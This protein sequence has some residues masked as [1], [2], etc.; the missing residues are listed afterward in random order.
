MSPNLAVLLAACLTD[1]Y[2]YY[3]TPRGVFTGFKYKHA[4]ILLDKT[5]LGVLLTQYIYST[6]T[7][8]GKKPPSH[9]FPHRFIQF[10]TTPPPIDPYHNALDKY[11]TIHHFVAEK[12]TR[13]CLWV[14]VRACVR[15]RVCIMPRAVECREAIMYKCS[16]FPQNLENEKCLINVF[17]SLHP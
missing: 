13:V 10:C 5:T 2:S 15:A 11:P 4:L 6:G 7:A 8:S 12:C 3:S 9:V 17:K 16:I 1:D 14:C